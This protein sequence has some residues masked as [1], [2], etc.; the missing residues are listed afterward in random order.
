MTEPEYGNFNRK[1]QY[2]CETCKGAGWTEA[3]LMVS[4]REIKAICDAGLG[5]REVPVERQ[6]CTRCQGTGGGKL[7]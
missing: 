3:R 5:D 7:K 1:H 6:R 4:M 2:P